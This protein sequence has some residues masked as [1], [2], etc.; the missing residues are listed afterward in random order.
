MGEKKN[1]RRKL[2]TLVIKLVSKALKIDNY[3]YFMR[4]VNVSG[5]YPNS[6]KI[7]RYFKHVGGSPF[8]KIYICL[9]NE[10]E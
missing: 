2:W 5:F 9:D 3:N 8:F 7:I 4:Y 10:C 1:F 6:S